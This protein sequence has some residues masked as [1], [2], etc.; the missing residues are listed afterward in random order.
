[1]QPANRIASLKP[2]FFAQLNQRI[3]G[4]KEKGVDVIRLDIGSPDL[5]P[6]D[7]I[8]QA[9][10]RRAAQADAHGYTVYGGTPA[11]RRACATYYQ[12]R[13]GVLL[14]YETQVV[15]LLGS[16]EGLFTLSQVLLDPGDVVLVPD[17]GYST[18]TASAQIAGAQVVAMPLLEKHGFLPD[19]AAIPESV[20]RR[21]RLMW[22]NYPNNPTGAVA[23]LEFFQQAVDFARRYDLIVAHDAP[24]VDVCFDGYQAP[25]ILQVPGA[26]EVAVEFNS[27][28]K[29]YNMAG[30]RLGMAVGNAEVV[31]YLKTYKSQVDTSHF[32]PIL[33]GG[34]TALTGDQGWIRERNTTYQERRDAVIAGLRAMGFEPNVPK[35]ALYVW[36]RIPDGW[37]DLEFCER[38]LRDTGVSTTPG[39]I[40]GQYGQGYFRISIC[41]PLRH[42]QE[43][44]SRLIDWT[45]GMM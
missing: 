5:P 32:D 9:M 1:M 41:T 35:A 12:N 21:A 4:L 26:I 45:Q 42:I 27:L 8:I 31:R 22:L 17:P 30:W 6:A 33:V 16:K 3:A 36:T 13:F 15:G 34:A 23:S 29:A 14:D 44:M 28:S 39:S 38:L 11:Y 7:F 25:S 43:A 10:T 24:Y 2:Y 19:L 18:Y 20:A 40:Y 37:N